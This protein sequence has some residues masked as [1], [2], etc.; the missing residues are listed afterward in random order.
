MAAFADGV[1]VP[2]PGF[3]K[4]PDGLAAV[5][6]R[7]PICIQM[8]RQGMSGLTAIRAGAK[9]AEVLAGHGNPSPA[10]SAFKAS[11]VRLQ[12]PPWISTTK[13]AVRRKRL[14]LSSGIISAIEAGRARN[15]RV[16]RWMP[17]NTAV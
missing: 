1:P 7:A 11:H 16:L 17:P 4:P 13:L 5:L 6:A 8:A 3:L 12:S 2:F 14:D 15:D 9:P 10:F